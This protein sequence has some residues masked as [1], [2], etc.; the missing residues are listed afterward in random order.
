[1]AISKKYGRVE[2]QHG[3]IDEDEPVIVFR[4][5]DARLPEVLADYMK[6]CMVAGSPQRHLDMIFE[7]YQEVTE[8]QEENPE[9]VKVADS[10][11]SRA[12]MP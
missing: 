9:Q 7:S 12:W 10:E 11:S 2:L 5:R 3:T 6:L 8:W 1:M 4:A